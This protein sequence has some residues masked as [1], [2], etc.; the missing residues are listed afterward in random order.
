MGAIIGLIRILLASAVMLAHIPANKLLFIDGQVAVLGF[1]I[2][3]GFYMNLVTTEKYQS[4]RSGF[5]FNRVLRLYPAY[6]IALALSIL[7][8][9]FNHTNHIFLKPEFAGEMSFAELMWYR[10]TNLIILGQ[11]ITSN[12]SP[13]F[14]HNAYN[15]PVSPAWTLASELIFYFVI[16]LL[17]HRRWMRISLMIAIALASLWVRT[18]WLNTNSYPISTIGFFMVG[19]LSYYLYDYIRA[20]SGLL[21]WAVGIILMIVVSAFICFMPTMID[22]N[23]TIFFTV[24]CLLSPFIFLVTKDSIIDRF[25]GELSYPVYIIHMVI[26]IGISLGSFSYFIM[27]GSHLASIVGLTLISALLIYFLVE[28][29]INK[30]RLRIAANSAK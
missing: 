14:F 18:H 11:D 24:I 23:Q 2:I 7:F 5:L 6:F 25:I 26:V 9:F 22:K 30:Y 17:P 15:H 8:A 20:Y 13:K 21:L 1:F 10:I 28:K 4:N 3:S 29:P 12:L 16:S 27:F 19:A